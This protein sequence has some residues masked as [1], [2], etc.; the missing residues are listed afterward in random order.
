MKSSDFIHDFI[1]EITF[2]LHN[3][4]W[5]LIINHVLLPWAGGRYGRTTAIRRIA[6][7]ETGVSWH[8]EGSH[9]NPPFIRALSY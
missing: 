2:N 1:Y 5:Q 8:H 4:I 7:R 3:M 9:K 6:V